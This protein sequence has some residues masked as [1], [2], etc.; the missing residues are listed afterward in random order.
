MYRL[1]T[2]LASVLWQRAE[3][4]RWGRSWAGRRRG[5][6]G[7]RQPTTLPR[8]WD[9]PG[10]NTGVGCHFLLQCMKVESESEVAQPCLTLCDPM[11]RSMP[12]LPVHHQ[13][14]EFM[15]FSQ[16]FPP[17]P[18]PTESKRLFYTSVSLLLSRI[19]GYHCHLSKFCGPQI[20]SSSP[21][22]NPHEPVLL[23]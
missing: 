2:L 3:G 4:G 11:N 9:S 19:Q 12:G 10:K 7:H 22:T 16:I 18:S 13:L 1:V 14:L 6:A 15:P 17:S 8:P 23:S 5:S 20:P 21:M